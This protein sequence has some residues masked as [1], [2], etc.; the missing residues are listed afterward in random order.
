VK[1][2]SSCL[3]AKGHPKTSVSRGGK[4][5]KQKGKVTE[6][7]AQK[8]FVNTPPLREETPPDMLAFL[9]SSIF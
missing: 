5:K 7:T 9:A 1:I 8:T 3:K 2:T 6:T 4:G